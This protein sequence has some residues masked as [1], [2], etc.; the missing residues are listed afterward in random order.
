MTEIQKRFIT[1]LEKSG[2]ITAHAVLDAARPASSPIHDCF[3][4]DDSEA[5]E[6]WRLEQ[7]RELIRRVKIELVYQEVSV[8][9]VKYVADP[10][11]SDGYTDIVKARAPSLSEIMSAEWRNV[12]ALAKRAQSI[13]TARGDRMPAGYLDRCAEAVA[14][15]E[16]MTEQYQYGD[17]GMQDS[18]YNYTDVGK[19]NPLVNAKAVLLDH[20]HP[21]T[22]PSGLT[23]SNNPFGVLVEWVGWTEISGVQTAQV[24]I[25]IDSV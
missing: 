23:T 13:A 5:A 4:W 18:R 10:A 17:I 11:R 6:K 25:T 15:I 12:L 1:G 8:R 7:A 14:M 22:N 21:S 16:T 3:D 9:T 19:T 24:T 20:A 2:R